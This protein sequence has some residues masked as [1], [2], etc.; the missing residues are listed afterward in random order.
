MKKFL[1]GMVA[2]VALTFTF[3]QCV[4]AWTSVFDYNGKVYEFTKSITGTSVHQSTFGLRKLTDPELVVLMTLSKASGSN[5][6]T[7]GTKSCHFAPGTGIVNQ[8]LSLDKSTS[9]T[10]TFKGNWKQTTDGVM[11]AS[12]DITNYI[13]F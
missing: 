13:P 1:V 10:A 9:G 5:W 6:V 7:L 12:I 4:H 11:N 3:V 2:V 8:G